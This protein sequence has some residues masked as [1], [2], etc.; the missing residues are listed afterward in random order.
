MRM[1]VLNDTNDLGVAVAEMLSIPVAPHEE[2]DFKDGEH[3][4]RPLVSVRGKDVYVL[5]SLAGGSV[6]SVNDKLCKLLFF[7]ATCRDNGASSITAIVP[8]LAYSRKDRQTKSRDPVTTR[9]VARL[10]EAVGTDRVITL[11]VHNIAVFQNA[12]R[13][14]TVHLDVRKLFVPVIRRL[15]KELPLIVFSPDSGGMK[16]AQL[17][18]ETLEAV[19]GKEVGF[20][21][22]EKRRSRNVVSGELFAGDVKGSAVFIV[23]DMISTGGTM[24]RTAHACRERGA[25]A[26][27][28]FATHG[29]FNPGCE[30]LFN[31]PAV[32]RVVVTDSVPLSHQ[33]GSEPHAKIEIVPVAA[34]IGEAI[35]RLHSNKSITDLLGDED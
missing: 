25:K 16:R 30:A 4:A 22:M 32:N 10:F 21:F 19:Q 18:K 2:R 29:L 1:F 5:Q 14:Q 7:I 33:T 20:G 11:E 26:V 28:V 34:L 15:A 24:L 31:S 23:D 17:L 12:F 8:Y 9:Y 27:Y 3:K 13:C 35:R 6:A